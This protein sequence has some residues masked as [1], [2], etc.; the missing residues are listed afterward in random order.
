[1]ISTICND[2]QHK[3]VKFDFILSTQ[4]I[5]QTFAYDSIYDYDSSFLIDCIH[6]VK[7]RYFVF[8]G[9][10]LHDVAS[11]TNYTTILLRKKMTRFIERIWFVLF[12]R[13]QVCQVKTAYNTLV[14]E[15]IY[16]DCFT[17]SILSFF[18][19]WLI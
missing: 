4:F 14:L 9:Q 15:C 13:F 5:T 17:E 10:S 7:K 1:M 3:F 12:C 6:Y 8:L 16:H 11:M 18:L 2:I 19:K